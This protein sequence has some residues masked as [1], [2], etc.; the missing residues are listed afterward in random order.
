[1]NALETISAKLGNKILAAGEHAI[2]IRGF[3][4][5]ADGTAISNV[6]VNGQAA[7]LT[8]FWP[9]G[10]TF[11][12]GELFLFPEDLPVNGITVAAAGNIMVIRS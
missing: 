9:N 2:K 7:A 1:M 3:I 5:R 10:T 12:K 11:A 4:S 8:D 6:L